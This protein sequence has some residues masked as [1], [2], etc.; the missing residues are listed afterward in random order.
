MLCIQTILAAALACS[1][2]ARHT[3]APLYCTCALAPLYCCDSNAV[4]SS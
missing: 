2:G 1:C 3:F 4:N